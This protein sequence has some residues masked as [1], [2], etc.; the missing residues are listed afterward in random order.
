MCRRN[1]PRKWLETATVGEWHRNEMVRETHWEPAF[2]M[3][4]DCVV[5][6][7]TT[8]GGRQRKWRTLLWIL[9]CG[10]RILSCTKSHFLQWL[11]VYA[12]EGTPVWTCLSWK[13]SL[14]L[15]SHSLSTVS[16]NKSS[17][18]LVHMGGNHGVP[19]LPSTSIV[20][21]GLC[22]KYIFQAC[23]QVLPKHLLFLDT[24]K[25]SHSLFYSSCQ[26]SSSCID[27]I[28]LL[29]F[30]AATVAQMFFSCGFSGLALLPPSCINNKDLCD[31]IGSPM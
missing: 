27:Y 23:I 5:F 25:K 26:K 4:R 7:R 12:A 2:D 28:L 24:Q 9:W 18:Y 16:S 29:S 11:V 22:L 15:Q 6:R 3:K 21:H 13:K 8:S 31:P 1:K 19:V 14:H 20:S 17:G 30:K 10:A